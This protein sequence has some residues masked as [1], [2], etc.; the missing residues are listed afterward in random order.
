LFSAW[1]LGL[2]PEHGLK[3]TS[4][5]QGTATRAPHPPA[6]PSQGDHEGD[7]RGPEFCDL[8]EFCGQNSERILG[9]TLTLG[10]RVDLWSSAP[11]RDSSTEKHL[12]ALLVDRSTREYLAQA[13]DSQIEAALTH[14]GTESVQNDDRTISRVMS[15]AISDRRDDPQSE[16]R[17]RDQVGPNPMTPCSPSV[18]MATC[19]PMRGPSF[20]ENA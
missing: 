14:V 2:G 10:P 6:E 1:G 16:P 18:T 5:T 12:A 3:P 11:S 7:H 4:G 15:R 19:T 13:S 8:C 20:V 17:L 9:G